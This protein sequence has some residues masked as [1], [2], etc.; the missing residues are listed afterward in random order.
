LCREDKVAETDP[1]LSTSKIHWGRV[2]NIFTKI[3]RN[4][5]KKEKKKEM[6][7]SLRIYTTLSVA[8]EKIMYWNS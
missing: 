6:K 8:N 4:G 7:S 5:K 2:A 1:S 3:S